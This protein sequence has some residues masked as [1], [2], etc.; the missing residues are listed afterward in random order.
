MSISSSEKTHCDNF[1]LINYKGN[2]LYFSHI[3]FV[4]LE[5]KRGS[6]LK[7]KE[8]KKNN[9]R[10]ALQIVFKRYLQCLIVHIVEKYTNKK[11]PRD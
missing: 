11:K 1:L 2:Y 3:S 4:F 6:P 9:I 7:I 8:E 5:I 10:L